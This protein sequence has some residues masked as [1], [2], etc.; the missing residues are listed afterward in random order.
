MTDKHLYFIT[1]VLAVALCWTAFF[2]LKESNEKSETI[3]ELQS[4]ISQGNKQNEQLETR[5]L[6]LNLTDEQIEKKLEKVYEAEQQVRDY[7]KMAEDTI[8]AGERTSQR[9]VEMTERK[10]KS[11]ID[12]IE[13]LKQNQ[14][15]LQAYASGEMDNTYVVTFKIKPVARGFDAI[16]LGKQMKYSMNSFTFDVPVAKNFYDTV[17]KGQVYSSDFKMGSFINSGTTSSY[18]VRVENKRV[19]K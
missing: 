2:H 9:M 12:H 11:Q 3:V 5:L 16:D 4:E 17:K 13:K 8:Q 6:I 7:K 1:S 18:E 10:L 19:S 15:V 14:R